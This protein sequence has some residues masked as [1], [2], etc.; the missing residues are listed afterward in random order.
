MNPH[1]KPWQISANDFPGDNAASDQLQFLVGYAILA[2]SP[3]NTQPWHF[4]IHS[5]HLDLHAD[6]HRQLPVADPEG[7]ELIASCGSALYN[8]RVAAE[9]FGHQHR[10]DF[11]PDEGQ[12][13]LLASLHLGLGAQTSSEDVL[14]FHAITRRHTNRQAFLD[15]PVP[16]TVLAAWEQAAAPL[17]A[18]LR[19]LRDEATR[20]AVADLVAEADRQQWADKAFRTELARWVR[21]RPNEHGDGFAASA[22]GIQDWLSFASPTL[23]RTFDRGNGQAATD[24]EIAL[25][26]PVLAVLG[27]ETDDVGAWLNAG[28]ALQKL[29]LSATTDG[30][31]ASF[32]NQPVEVP[33]LRQNLAETI[34][35][36]GYPQAVLRLGYGPAPAPTVRRQ[37]REVLLP[38]R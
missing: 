36:P 26:S 14:Q 2:P 16:E 32:L 13:D 7:R 20:L 31:W 23:V 34:G 35:C 15:Q 33:E 8:L 11:F 4:R 37:V 9:Y 17:G 6:W 3:L 24:R 25:H 30:I 29:L 38:W 28:Q 21:P 5:R 12:P 19:I 1:L 22:L 10:V 18:W 27:T